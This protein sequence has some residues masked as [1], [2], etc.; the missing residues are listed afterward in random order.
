MR[1]AA[2]LAALAL[3]LGGAVVARADENPY[4]REDYAAFRARFP[5]LLEPNYLPF[6]TYRVAEPRGWLGGLRQRLP[7][8]LGGGPA[9]E[10]LVFCHWE[11]D[12]LP[13][14]VYVEAPR[15]AAELEDEFRPRPPE[16]YVAAVQR[17]LA[18]WE[19]DLEGWIRFRPVET[20]DEA[21]LHVRLVGEPAPVEDPEVQVLGAAPV[22]R[23]CRVVGG[24][25]GSGRLA[26]RYRLAELRI[27]IADQHGLLL[28]DQVERVA[29]H[30]LG[31]ALGM[32]GHSPIPAD[33]MF[34]QA[35]D[36]LGRE[37]LGAEDVNSF[38]SLYSIPS[39]TVYKEIDSTPASAPPR[40]PQ[41]PP[42]L[43]LAPHV[44]ARLG[45]EL[46]PPADWMRIE[47]P[48]GVVLV[49]GVPWDYEASLQIVVRRYESLDAYLARFGP[50]HL[51]DG[52]VRSIS[53]LSLA[54]RPAKRV[55]VETSHDTVEELS[56]LETEDGRVVIVTAEAPTAL[57]ERYH[58][59]FAAALATLELAL[60]TGAAD[61]DYLERAPR[62]LPGAAPRP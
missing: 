22:R 44:D 6:M 30:E 40:G 13:L 18:I 39:G 5:T 24:D 53:E 62:A 16:A 8:W 15:I 27:Y 29:L 9:R 46:Q 28:P 51:R 20:P 59:H 34:E 10:L 32:P 11:H 26:V 4:R 2:G 58:A 43:A 35:R 31:H 49:D 55:V 21:A 37:G 17:A 60:P 42:R 61:R 47:T 57:H 23:A 38:L 7:G 52:R 3:V 56:F 1:A 41:G 25:P 54:G 36:R 48:Y 45:F 14:A 50:G 12:D 33:L 19:R